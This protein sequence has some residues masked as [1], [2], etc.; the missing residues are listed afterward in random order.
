MPFAL[1]TE[2]DFRERRV[3]GQHLRIVEGAGSED[4][5]KCDRMRIKG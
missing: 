3:P 4:E 2:G 1:G 5:R